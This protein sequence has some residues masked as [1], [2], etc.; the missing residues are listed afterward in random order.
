MSL[1]HFFE[2]SECP[3]RSCKLQV[4]GGR[5]FS[6]VSDSSVDDTRICVMQIEGDGTSVSVSGECTIGYG[7]HGARPATETRRQRWELVETRRVSDDVE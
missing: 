1:I 6:T 4:E 2:C 7:P 3:D 5:A